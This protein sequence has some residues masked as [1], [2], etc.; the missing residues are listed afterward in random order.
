[1]T[2]F[3]YKLSSEEF[4]PRELVRLGRLAEESGFEFALISD[5]FHPWTDTQGQSPFV[6]SVIG[7][8]A[9]ATSRL[10]VGTGVTCPTIRTHPAVIAQ[11]AATSAVMLPGRF[12]LGVGTGE[13]L[14][15][16]I[17][18]ARWPA[19]DVRRAMLE[20]AIDVIRSLWRGGYHDHHGRFFTV[21][22]ARLYTR[23][24]TP[25]PIMIAA[26]GRKSAELAGRL[27][28]GL[29]ATE[30]MRE[31]VEAFGA[32]GGGGKPRYAEILVCW[33][34]DEPSA[35]RTAHRWWP[36]AGF[37]GPLVTELAIPA[38]FEAAAKM[39]T[40]DAVAEAVVCGPDPERHLARIREYAAAGFDHLCV[41]QV[42]PDQEG[43]LRFYAQ[44]VLPRLA[45]RRAAA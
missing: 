10:V 42:G 30:P 1:M 7:G 37:H 13:N 41:H 14:N 11:A 15:E 33:A 8:L 38:H 21:E 43:F 20:E 3:G 16:H 4:G 6:W 5:H 45:E 40:E 32:A 29:V 34:R 23:P 28:D 2:T 12:F 17:V 19:I 18:G 44:D 22:R 27:G 31:L 36:L 9:E 25:P 39:V 35:R 26:S 24:E